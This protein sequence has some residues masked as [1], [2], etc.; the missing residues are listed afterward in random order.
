M[1]LI[2][3]RKAELGEGFQVGRALPTR[4]RRMVGAWCFLDHL[5]PVDLTSGA[6][7]HVGPHPHTC[8]Q[9]FTW[10]IR[11]EILHRDSLGS[12]QVVRPGQVNLMTA[13]P[14]IAHTE[15]SLEGDVLHAVQLW[16]ALPSEHAGVAPAFDHYPELPAWS[17]KGVDFTLLVGEFEGRAA[18]TRVHSPLLA[19]DLHAPEGG[20]VELPL[21]TGFEYGVLA[22][23]GGLTLR[24]TVIGTDTFAYLGPGADCLPLAL[25]PGG[26]CLLI[27]GE[28]FGETISMWWNFVAAT[29]SD[30][31]QAYQDWESGSDRFPPVPGAES[32]RLPSPRPPWQSLSST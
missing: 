21:R 18:P 11:G 29:R 23:S 22:T 7:M 26:R 8:L 27:G 17:G 20:K 15:D 31:D 6:G 13:G 25:P 19:L 4:E 2:E 30:I 12:E 9:T 32:E 10:M 5:G 24:D 3:L 16:I 28:P 14:G 1:Q